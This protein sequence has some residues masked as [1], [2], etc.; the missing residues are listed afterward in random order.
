MKVLSVAE[1]PSV[2]LAIA[3]AL[4]TNGIRTRPRNYGCATHDISCRLMNQVFFY[5][6]NVFILI[7][8]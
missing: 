4:A 6:C 7:E 5:I 3:Q 2:A 1:K 8:C